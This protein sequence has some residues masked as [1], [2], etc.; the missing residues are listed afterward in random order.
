MQFYV[1]LKLFICLKGSMIINRLNILLHGNGMSKIFPHII[2]KGNQIVS[3]VKAFQ[4]N[5]LSKINVYSI[6]NYY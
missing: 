1:N 5:K 6:N 4:L 3:F 2:F